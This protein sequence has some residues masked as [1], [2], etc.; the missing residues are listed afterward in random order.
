MFPVPTRAARL[1]HNAWKE[2]MPALS[3]LRLFLRTVKVWVK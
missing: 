2:E 3:A 1:V